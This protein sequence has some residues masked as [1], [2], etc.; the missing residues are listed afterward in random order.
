MRPQR[1]SE[2]VA[3]LAKNSPTADRV[4]TL[5]ES[6]D[7]EHPFGVVVTVGTTDTRWQFTGQLP[8]GAKHEGFLDEPVAG[9]PIPAGEPPRKTDSP[10]AWLAAVLA[11]AASPEISAVERWSTPP[12]ATSQPG[13]TITFHNGARVFARAF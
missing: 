11:Q 5:A 7:T 9:P 6:G 3:D 12:E 8:E 2:L 13:L 10:E 1:F 4:R